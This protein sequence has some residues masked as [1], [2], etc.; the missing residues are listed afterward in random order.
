M[1]MHLKADRRKSPWSEMILIPCADAAD[2]RLAPSVDRL[3][4]TWRSTG[5]RNPEVC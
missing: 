1:M 4:S 2:H 5:F 3:F